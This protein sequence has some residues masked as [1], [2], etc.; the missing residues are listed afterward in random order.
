MKSIVRRR[1]V[2]P[3]PPVSRASRDTMVPQM[4]P[5]DSSRVPCVGPLPCGRICALYPYDAPGVWPCLSGWTIDK[6]LFRPK[7]A[8]CRTEPRRV[9]KKVRVRRLVSR[10]ARI[11]A[12]GREARRRK[13]FVLATGS[14]QVSRKANGSQSNRNRTI[15]KPQIRSLHDRTSRPSR[16]N[17]YPRCPCVR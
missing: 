9:H 12:C 10:Q 15:T 5:H 11:K 1:K 6:S 13:R 14:L 17:V 3:F 4:P 8:F 16:R 2:G 7:P